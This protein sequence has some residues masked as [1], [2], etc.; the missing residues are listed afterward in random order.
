M[1]KANPDKTRSDFQRAINA[2]QDLFVSTCKHL[3]YTEQKWL[4]EV[5]FLD[6]AIRWE[7]FISDLIERYVNKDSTVVAADLTKQVEK[8]FGPFVAGLI[9]RV[10]PKHV[11]QK[12]IGRLIDPREKNITFSDGEELAKGA[13]KYLAPKYSAKFLNLSKQDRASITAWT[14]IRHFLAH[15]SQRAMKNMNAALGHADLTQGATVHLSVTG[16]RVKDVGS[17][18]RAKPVGGDESRVLLYLKKMSQ[19]A[20]SL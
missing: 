16:W 1:K 4:A 11:R 20:A 3:K 6:C 18:L 19:V 9:Q 8:Q 7:G 5:V 2:A 15:R 13:E 17:W 14:S 10:L 12:D